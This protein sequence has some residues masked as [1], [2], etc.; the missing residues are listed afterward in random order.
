MQGGHDITKSILTLHDFWQDFPDFRISPISKVY[1]KTPGSGPNPCLLRSVMPVKYDQVS[2]M[3]WASLEQPQMLQ[4]FQ[5]CFD[6][7]MTKAVLSNVS[8]TEIQV[9]L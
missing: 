9:V 7:I 4:Y 3:I 6:I 5:T 1:D 2:D 8:T